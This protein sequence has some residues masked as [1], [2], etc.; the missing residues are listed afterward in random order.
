MTKIK[1]SRRRLFYLSAGSI[2]SFTAGVVLLGKRKLF[3]STC[4]NFNSTLRGKNCLPVENEAMASLQNQ[5]L[6]RLLLPITVGA[7]VYKSI[8]SSIRVEKQCGIVEL[9]DRRGESYRIDICGRDQGKTG[10]RPIAATRSFELFLA[11]NGKGH[12]K[13]NEDRGKTLI[14]LSNFIRRNENKGIQL[15]LNT[16]RE[17]WRENKSC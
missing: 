6:N 11:N 9:K 13:T 12:K 8:V 1:I 10:F 5:Q 2:G 17:L 14:V 7:R 15:T 16:K 4:G 3:K